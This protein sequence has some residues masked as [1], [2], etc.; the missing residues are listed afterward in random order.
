MGYSTS[1]CCTANAQGFYC[2]CP[3]RIPLENKV[4]DGQKLTSRELS[5]YEEAMRKKDERR[6]RL[7]LERDSLLIVVGILS[8]E[9]SMLRRSYEKDSQI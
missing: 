2:D 6:V 8:E 3:N 4:S 7:Q 5:K 9:I 1:N